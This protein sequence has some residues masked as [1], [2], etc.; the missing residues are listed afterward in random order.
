MDINMPV[1]NGIEA[2]MELHKIM[3]SNKI[4]H[5]TIIAVTA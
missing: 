5:C 3:E 1:M 2:T 4:K